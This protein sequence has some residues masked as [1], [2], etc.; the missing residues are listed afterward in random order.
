MTRAEALAAIRVGAELVEERLEL[1]DVF[2][3]GEMGIGNSTSA[4][5]LTAALCGAPPEAV[6]GAGTGVDGPGI[7]RKRRIVERAVSRTDR[8]LDP[9][10]VLAEVGGLEIAG[11]VG[12]VLAAARA[13]RPVVTDGFIATAAVLVAVRLAPAA[14]DYVVASHRSCEPGHAV[15]LQAL[16][17]EP[18]LDLDLR[19]GEGTGAA[20]ALPLLDAAAAM[21]REMA[22]FAD[23]GVSTATRMAEL[24]PAAVRMKPVLLE[25]PLEPLS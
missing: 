9:L 11:L 23:A 24:A 15:L 14:L 18:L 7:A 20:L 13:G 12:V 3:L 4:A 8:T 25:R 1:S 2:A 22:S 10:D 17:L 6:V 19:L 16:G 21:L 5:A